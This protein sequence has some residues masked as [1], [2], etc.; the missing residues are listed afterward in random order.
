MLSK[1]QHHLISSDERNR[2]DLTKSLQD[3]N[4]KEPSGTMFFVHQKSQHCQLPPTDH[5][6][7]RRRRGRKP[8]PRCRCMG[9]RG[10]SRL[11]VGI[12]GS[13][14]EVMHHRPT[15]PTTYPAQL[16]GHS[17]SQLKYLPQCSPQTVV[18]HCQT[19]PV[20]TVTCHSRT[21]ARCQCNRPSP[22]EK[23]LSQTCTEA[24]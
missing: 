1:D 21:H 23:V 9:G 8:G 2:T 18:C 24:P 22:R 11:P 10:P 14:E 16:S 5:R 15:Y 17:Q 3:P 13:S 12:Q 20:K 7:R 19:H 4:A 6:S